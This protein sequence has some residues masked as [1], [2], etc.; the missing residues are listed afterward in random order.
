MREKRISC[1]M[2]NPFRTSVFFVAYVVMTVATFPDAAALAARAFSP[3]LLYLPAAAIAAGVLAHARIPPRLPAS[4]GWYVALAGLAGVQLAAAFVASPWLAFVKP[5]L[6]LAVALTLLAVRPRI[7]DLY[8]SMTMPGF[9][10]FLAFTAL[11][12]ESIAPLRDLAAAGISH[13]AIERVP[14]PMANLAAAAVLAALFVMATGIR[15]RSL[16][17]SPAKGWLA[18]GIVVFLAAA[19]AMHSKALLEYAR[20]GLIA[21]HVLLLVGATYLLSHLLPGREADRL[22]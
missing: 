3:W 11:I 9:T 19:A 2:G 8:Q 5:A 20:Y 21:S 12:S 15:H 10:A 4:A 14:W 6:M 22:A 17:P 16:Q 1:G 18:A 7:G 13:P